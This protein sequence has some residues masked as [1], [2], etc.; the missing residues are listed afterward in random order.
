[1]KLPPHQL[2]EHKFA[3]YLKLEP[4]NMV[5]CSS[6]TAALH[7]G[8]EALNLNKYCKVIIPNYTMIACVRAVTLARL[9]P[10]LADC[11]YN[12]L[13][14]NNS[15]GVH[16][17]IA[18]VMAVHIYGRQCLMNELIHKTRYIKGIKIIEDLAELQ[19]AP[20]RETD[21]ACYSFYKNKVIAG[22]EGGAVYFKD[23]EVAKKARMLRNLGSTPLNDYNHIPYGC[24][25]RM[26]DCLAKPILKSLEKVKYN[27]KRRKEIE[28][29]YSEHLHTKLR[30]AFSTVIPWVYDIRVLN[31]T[32]EVL[33]NKVKI[34]NDKGIQARLGFLPI[35]KQLEYIGYAHNNLKESEAAGETVFYL[36]LYEDGKP[37]KED[38]IKRIS[39]I[40]NQL[41]EVFF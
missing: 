10:Q 21:V 40:V 18:A 37:I 28:L 7:L 31:G 5:V 9:H 35:S 29:C 32:R 27:I 41:F 12:L 34:L 19:I 33:R 11:R 23:I 15:F 17:A 22:E 6:G 16:N 25:Y 30:H 24:N 2:L 14:D 8:I 20:H 26:A 38:R 13:L 3:E 1:M 36:P 4:S 39:K